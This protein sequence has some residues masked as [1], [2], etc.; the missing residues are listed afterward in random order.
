MAFCTYKNQFVFINCTGLF[1]IQ[2]IICLIIFFLTGIGR[3]LSSNLSDSLF[4]GIFSTASPLLLLALAVTALFDAILHLLQ[5]TCDKK[6]L[7]LG[8]I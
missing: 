2:I 8:H 4:C 1:L 7:D 6:T 3:G 5:Y